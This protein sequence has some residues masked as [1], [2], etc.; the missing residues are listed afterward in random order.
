MLGYWLLVMSGGMLVLLLSQ[1]RPPRGLSRSL[2][3]SVLCGL[4]DHRCELWGRFKTLRWFTVQRSKRG[5][6]P[7]LEAERLCRR[8]LEAVLGEGMEALATAHGGASAM[9]AKHRRRIQSMQF[10]DP[11]VC[12]FCATVL[13]P[14]PVKRES[15]EAAKKCASNRTI[16]SGL[17]HDRPP[18]CL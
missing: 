9:D 3:L 6:S 17:D 4:N 14:G 7:Q 15:A 8:A 5:L 13:Y 16:L 18:V 10:V 2:Y 1:A 11:I 12:F